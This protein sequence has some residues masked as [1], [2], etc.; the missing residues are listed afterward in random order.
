MMSEEAKGL[1][2]RAIPFH[3]T[4]GETGI[5]DVL[6]NAIKLILVE[7]AILTEKEKVTEHI[8]FLFTPVVEP[9]INERTFLPKDP[10]LLGRKFKAFKYFKTLL[11]SFINMC[12]AKP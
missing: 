2:P 3:G 10:V 8:L 12:S 7:A 11:V 1:S 4:G 5:F 6:E 9:Y